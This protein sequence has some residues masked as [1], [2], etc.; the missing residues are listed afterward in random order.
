MP[1]GLS[2]VL[3]C[4]TAGI[5]ILVPLRT[6]PCEVVV[7]SSFTGLK[8]LTAGESHLFVRIASLTCVNTASE[9]VA[10]GAD[11]GFFVPKSKFATSTM[12]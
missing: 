12:T 8:G 11:L 7:N 9:L 1:D 6:M 5:T 10:S 2:I 3:C 4:R